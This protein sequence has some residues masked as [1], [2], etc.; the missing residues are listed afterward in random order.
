MITGLSLL[1]IGMLIL[2]MIMMFILISLKI[3][4]Q[5]LMFIGKVETLFTKEKQGQI[6]S[7]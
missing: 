6:T 4:E 1:V 2:V 7:I 5:I 3:A